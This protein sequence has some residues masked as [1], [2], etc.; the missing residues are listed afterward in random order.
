MNINEGL[1]N[2]KVIMVDDIN[3]IPDDVA[4]GDVMLYKYKAY[5]MLDG[6]PLSIDNKN[7]LSDL[8]VS[9]FN[10]VNLMY[11]GFSKPMHWIENETYPDLSAE[12]YKTLI[13][14]LNGCGGSG[15]DTF[16]KML[17][18]HLVDRRYSVTHISSIDPMR[19]LAVEMAKM[20]DKEIDIINDKDKYRKLLS[21]LKEVWDNEFNGSTEYIMKKIKDDRN[22]IMSNAEQHQTFFDFAANPYVI[23]PETKAQVVFVHIRE[24]KNIDKLKQRLWVESPDYPFAH[25]ACLIHGR[26][27]PEDFD[28]TSDSMVENYPYDIY[29]NN[30]GTLEDLDKKAQIL[31]YTID[32]WNCGYIGNFNPPEV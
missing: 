23:M 28:N 18:Q 15:K 29:L 21:R 31:A 14:V 25:A 19:E 2:M 30:N 22:E 27:N 8:F 10:S 13:I 26:T 9:I 24:P 20:S 32:C 16:E 11:S 5:M 4:D 7:D 3:N 1:T 12:S 17:T 6:K